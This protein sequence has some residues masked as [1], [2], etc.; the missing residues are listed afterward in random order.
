MFVTYEICETCMASV[1]RAVEDVLQGVEIDAP[2]END[3]QPR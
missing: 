2:V 3:K 1:E